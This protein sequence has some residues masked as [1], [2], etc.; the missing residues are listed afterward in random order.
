MSLD[1]SAYFKKYEALAAEADALFRTIRDRTGDLVRCDKG[2]CDCCYALFDLTLIEALY[3]NRRFNQA[4]EGLARSTILERA[5]EADRRVYKFKRSLY[6]ASEQGRSTEEILKTAARERLRCP[7]LNDSE[8]CD[9]YE[10]R[11]ITCRLYGV[12]TAFGGRAHTCA[13]SGFTPGRPYPTVHLDKIQD[14]LLALSR[15]LVAGLNTKH[16]KMGEIFMPPSMALMTEFDDDYLGIIQ[17]RGT[18][19]E[20]GSC[21]QD[22]SACASCQSFSVT[23]GKAGG[24]EDQGGGRG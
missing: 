22:D 7:L 20:C 9:L 18:A 10:H 19:P 24:G 13:K 11:P 1:F 8:L 6:K 16:K 2:C 12:P 14:R 3:L 17:E 4:F 21:D 23:I 5:D 15:E